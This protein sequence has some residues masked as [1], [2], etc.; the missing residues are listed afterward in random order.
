MKAGAIG[1]KYSLRQL[2]LIRLL[3]FLVPLAFITLWGAYWSTL[4][5]AN[6]AFDRSLARRVYA[7][8]DQIEVVRG[9]VVFD[10]PQSAHDILEF[11][12]TDIFYFR[13]V[14][15]NGEYL[16]GSEELLLPPAVIQRQKTGQLSYFDTRVDDKN[17]R[18]AAYDLSLKGTRAKGSV[19]LLAGE[20]TAKRTKLADEI[21]LTVLLPMIAVVGLMIYAISLAV[22]M[23]L[24]P[25]RAIRDAIA[26]RSPHDLEPIRLQ[27][28]PAEIDPL[29]TEMN[30]LMA[31]LRALHDS[32]QRFLADSAHQLRTPLASMRAQTELA[33]RSV[34]DEGSRQALSGL[35]A[36]LDRQSRLVNQLLALA[37]AENVLADAVREEVRLDEMA[38]NVAAEWAPR[39]LEH[40]IELA[41]ESADGPVGIFGNVH[42]LTEALTNLLD[43]ALRYCRS[44]D[45]IT[46][47]VYTEDSRACLAVADNGPGVPQQALSKLFQRFYRVPGSQAEG[48][49]LGL[50]IVRQVAMACDGE[51]SARNRPEGGLEV[52]M[53]FPHAPGANQ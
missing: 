28:M 22:D 44:G 38:R 1:S 20:T 11:D 2:L 36:S 49:G 4:H 35:L 26:R 9:K 13:I 34:Q 5:Y 18:V 14:G 7:M 3:V 15:P 31:D 46:V 43:N 45:Q 12:P 27:G 23:S 24:K 53:C 10:L 16:A 50:A 25:V 21:L 41:Y 30:Q 47:R 37:R 48:C 39:A 52:S 33:I 6:A 51:A 29:L 19:I 42:A 17:V 40:G 8:A 32:R